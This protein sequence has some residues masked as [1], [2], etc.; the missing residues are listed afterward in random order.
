M[1]LLANLLLDGVDKELERRGHRFG[2]YAEES[3]IDVK[4]A[5]TGQ[6]VLASVAQFLERRLKRTGKTA[7]SAGERPWRRPFL[8]FTFTGRRPHR[9]PFLG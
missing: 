6:R 2:R 3:N 9:R 5:R 8:G 4:S 7:Q 1:P